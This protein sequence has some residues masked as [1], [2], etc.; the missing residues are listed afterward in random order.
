MGFANRKE[1][2]LV[3]F[4]LTP[5]LPYSSTLRGLPPP[6]RALS[7]ACDISSV[8]QTL[9]RSFA[10]SQR[11]FCLLDIVRPIHAFRELYST[12]CVRRASNCLV[13]YILS[14][15]GR[16]DINGSFAAQSRATIHAAATGIEFA[17]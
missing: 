9:R 3:P 1:I 15:Y 2:T 12:R 16:L 6:R 11:G 4:S 10:Y 13:P 7:P 17:A 5:L 8:F 14:P